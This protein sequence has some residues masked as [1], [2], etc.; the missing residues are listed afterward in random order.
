MSNVKQ[1]KDASGNAIDPKTSI[2]ALTSTGGGGN[3]LTT[4]NLGGVTQTTFTA[5]D[6]LKAQASATPDN[7]ASFNENGGL[8][9]SNCNES[10]FIK[11]VKKGTEALTPVDGVV[12][13]PS[14]IEGAQA[15]SVLSN[16][17]ATATIDSNHVL[18][19]EIPR[20]ADGQN[21]A[22]A[23]NPF[24]GWFDAVVTGEAGS[25][26]ITSETQNLP[27]TPLVGD[28]A[29]VKTWDISG[30]A[31]SQT[32][33][34]IAKIYECTTAGSWSNSG[35]TA[36]TSNVQ[37]FASGEEVNEVAVDNTELK[38][39]DTTHNA[40]AKAVD[41]NPIRND[42]ELM[43]NG[44]VETT[45]HFNAGDGAYTA[46][47]FKFKFI[48]GHKYTIT[49]KS[50]DGTDVST[51]FSI[52]KT[53]SSAALQS[54]VQSSTTGIRTT[55]KLTCNTDDG[56]YLFMSVVSSTT[57]AVTYTCVIE[58]YDA[59]SLDTHENKIEY[60]EGSTELLETNVENIEKSVFYISSRADELVQGYYNSNGLQEVNYV[61]SLHD[62]IKIPDNK[63]IKANSDVTGTS[64]MRIVLYLK[65][66]SRYFYM[67]NS[68]FNSE[69]VTYDCSSYTC[70]HYRVCVFVPQSQSI[71]PQDCD[72]KIA[73]YCDTIEKLDDSVYDLENRSN[74][75]EHNN[76]I[77]KSVLFTRKLEKNELENASYYYAQR[78]EDS[79][80]VSNKSLL[81][82]PANKIIRITSEIEGTSTI[83]TI[84]YN[85]DGKSISGSL[86]D[87]TSSTVI[88]DV[89][90]YQNAMFYRFSIW[91]SN[92]IDLDD[93]SEKIT[94]SDNNIPVLYDKYNKIEDYIT[95]DGLE[96]SIYKAIDTLS[97]TTSNTE[98]D[99]R[100]IVFSDP[101]RFD[102]DAYKTY[103]ELYKTGVA[104]VL[105][106]LGDYVPYVD[107]PKSECIDKITSC[108]S[109]AGRTN[110]CIY[111]IGNHDVGVTLNWEQN[112]GVRFA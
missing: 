60:L 89:S 1:L 21:G 69:S 11:G 61:V 29:Y 23:V 52:R 31:P 79:K 30:T 41:V 80:R 32:E 59:I 75:I 110:D 18:Q 92:N 62:F 106:G 54:F 102:E 34:P 39:P 33:T 78:T 36:D 77:T 105:L 64:T 72:R 104:D 9:D 20:G 26:V 99:F 42:V 63:I 107:M 6:V 111:L 47:Y 71:T 93:A 96:K 85:L 67:G 70:T 17:S 8:Q 98:A 56:N 94:A 5:N 97:N 74:T 101:H 95:Y 81:S 86:S 103:K 84:L 58:D 40:I 68:D 24:K 4:N 28:Y 108:L 73:V 15:T 3:F 100:I 7:C 109:T 44:K 91:S 65:N 49:V 55:L 16:Q 82:I 48:N 27:A 25:R 38:N 66:N 87:R 2:D 57:T 43:K 45:F 35:R 10:T 22:D 12:T 50:I 51:Q 88:R 83:R 76:E 19:L 13:V 90:E 53:K 46:D 14:D 37:T 112:Y